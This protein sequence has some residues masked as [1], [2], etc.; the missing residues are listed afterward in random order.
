[1]L[2]KVAK[3]CHLVAK[4]DLLK[5]SSS[6]SENSWC[7]LAGQTVTLDRYCSAAALATGPPLQ[8]FRV[9]SLSFMDLSPG[10][11][12]SLTTLQ[13]AQQISLCFQE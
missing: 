9:L 13:I 11:Q 6:V 1:M 8:F 2:G 4:H 7:S 10:A 5:V 12:A 3:I